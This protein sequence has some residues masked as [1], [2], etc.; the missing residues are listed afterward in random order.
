M[1]KNGKP[2]EAGEKRAQD[3][4]GLFP[5]DLQALEAANQAMIEHVIAKTRAEKLARA[6]K[7]A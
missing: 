7:D 1:E 2:I 6:R 5:S 4:E 3:Q